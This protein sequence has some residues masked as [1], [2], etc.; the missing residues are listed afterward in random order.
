MTRAQEL[1]KKNAC[2]HVQL[3][4]KVASN[5]VLFEM[6]MRLTC[7]LHRFEGLPL[8]CQKGVIFDVDESTTVAEFKETCAF[9]LTE[10]LSQHGLPRVVEIKFLVYGNGELKGHLVLP[11]KKQQWPITSSMGIPSKWWASC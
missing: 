6:S 4:L 7:L 3:K 10:L 11:A 8:E 1:D 9:H 2:M 5:S